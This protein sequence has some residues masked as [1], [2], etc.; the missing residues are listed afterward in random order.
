MVTPSGMFFHQAVADGTESTS[1]FP[2]KPSEEN[3]DNYADKH[4]HQCVAG[5]HLPLHAR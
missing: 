2:K 5:R 4:I 3:D 1:Q